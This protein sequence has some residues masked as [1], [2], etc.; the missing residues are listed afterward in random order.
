M[1]RHTRPDF[2]SI[3]LI[4][5]D[6]QRDTP[7]DPGRREMSSIGVVLVTTDEVARALEPSAD[8]RV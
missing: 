8:H 4:T 7:D 3:A 6:T 2:R 5:I 1:S